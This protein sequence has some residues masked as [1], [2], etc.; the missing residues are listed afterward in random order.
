MKLDKN[1]D[2]SR[3]IRN[4]L[5]NWQDWKKE[6]YNNNFA[7]SEYA[8]K[9]NLGDKNNENKTNTEYLLLWNEDNDIAYGYKRH[10]KTEEDFIK[11]VKDEF[12]S[13]EGKECRV[14]NIRIETCIKSE[15]GLP[16][17]IVA[18]LSATDIEIANYYTTTVVE[19]DY[20]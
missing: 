18:P 2:I 5:E 15:K 20:N 1:N 16:E 12:K 10:F 11:Q 6:E 7:I 19:L 13:F 9:L 14:E 4:T 17:D 8:K 3:N